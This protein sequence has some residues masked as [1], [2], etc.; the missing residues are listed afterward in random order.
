MNIGIESLSLYVPE[1]YLDLH[2]LAVA[3][4]VDSEK[5]SKGIGQ[6][7]MAIPA[8]D[9][10]VVTMGA[11]AAF[12]ALEGIDRD[13]V[14]TV[15]F[16]TETGID[17]SKAASIYVHGLLGLPSS[18]RCFEVKQACCSSTA[19]LQ[20]ALSMVALKPKKRILIIASDIARYGIET[21][22][23][24][25]QGAGA[26]AMVVSAT[27]KLV[28]VDI[29][30]G[31]YTEDVMD[32]WRP[33]YRDEALVDGK[34]SIKIYLKALDACWNSYLQ[35]REG[36]SL[37]EFSRFCYHLPFTRM[38]QKAH[39]HLL[40]HSGE[41]IDE[42]SFEAQIEPSLKYNR[43]V[44]NCYTASLYIGLLSL[45]ENEESDLSGERVGLFSYGSGCMGS[46]FGATVCEGYREA[47]QTKRHREMLQTRRAINLEQYARF[48]EHQLPQDG[49]DYRTESH[50]HG[51]YRIAGIQD[52]KRLYELVPADAEVALSPQQAV[53]AS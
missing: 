13:T 9:E 14:D 29:E 45:L 38:A 18:T 20:M 36:A 26:I 21:A 47:L 7:K 44:G 48:Y 10:D 4:G 30:S 1:N 8:P 51:Q 19:A 32:F 22:G 25:T 46:F 24:P 6:E 39:K 17:Q 41:S 43:I 5:F 16:A 2:E 28:K 49:S 33:N 23:E 35:E 27:P 37:K 15:I 11:N 52:H 40:K 31:S 34:Y 53:H 42:V 12:H 50:T 3:R